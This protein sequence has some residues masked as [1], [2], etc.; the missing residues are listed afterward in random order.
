[1]T[2]VNIPYG[3]TL[4]L[5]RISVY[6]THRRFLVAFVCPIVLVVPDVPAVL[7]VPV[8]QLGQLELGHLGQ[9]GNN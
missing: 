3:G 8:R 5:G 1:M 4:T 6:F 2:G 7:V 9:L